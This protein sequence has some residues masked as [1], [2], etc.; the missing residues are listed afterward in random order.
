MLDRSSPSRP[1]ATGRMILTNSPYLL[2]R[3][4]TGFFIPRM[5]NILIRYAVGITCFNIQ[6]LAL[7]YP[8]YQIVSSL[9]GF[10]LYGLCH[11]ITC[12][13]PCPTVIFYFA[14][15]NLP[16]NEELEKC[17]LTQR[18]GSF[19]DILHPNLSRM[20][21]NMDLSGGYLGCLFN[22]A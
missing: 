1:R 10:R 19:C 7:I 2:M 3:A 5:S 17:S 4:T 9:G 12:F 20:I 15:M 8:I 6:R 11:R 14:N 21:W 18:F 16:K 13:G 22:Y